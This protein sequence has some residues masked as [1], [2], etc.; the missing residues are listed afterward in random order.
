M[1]TEGYDQPNPLTDMERMKLA[2]QEREEKAKEGKVAEVP[3]ES[4]VFKADI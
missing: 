2:K 1:I 3:C 4:S